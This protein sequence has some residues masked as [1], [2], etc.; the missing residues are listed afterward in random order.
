MFEM[1]G[2]SF[3]AVTVTLKPVAVDP[4]F[5]SL[6]VTVM[7]SEPDSSERQL[8]LYVVCVPLPARRMPCAITR[9]VL[10]DA[11]E[12]ANADAVFLPAAIPIGNAAVAESSAI[13]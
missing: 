4:P 6:T 11:A 1:V 13:D 3:T 12:T 10:D 5:P 9:L 7:R 2:A 8:L